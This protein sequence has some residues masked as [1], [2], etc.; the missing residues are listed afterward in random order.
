MNDKGDLQM[1][2]ALKAW[3]RCKDFK[4]FGL[5]F[6]P[7]WKALGLTQQPP[8]SQNPYENW[9]GGNMAPDVAFILNSFRLSLDK[10]TAFVQGQHKRLG[11]ALLVSSVD[12]AALV[13]IVDQVLGRRD[14][15]NWTWQATA[16][17]RVDFEVRQYEDMMASM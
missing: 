1:A 8:V 12:E 7:H 9:R 13:M 14:V 11:S 2:L 17:M 4:V 10:V 16:A 3:P 5:K 15:R 6:G